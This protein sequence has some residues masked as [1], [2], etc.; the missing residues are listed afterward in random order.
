MSPL[1]SL[2][3]PSDGRSGR[4]AC[5]TSGDR[6]DRGPDSG[7]WTTGRRERARCETALSCCRRPLGRRNGTP[8]RRS[9]PSLSATRNRA[10]GSHTTVLT[11]GNVYPV[12]DL[13][14]ENYRNRIQYKYIVLWI[15]RGRTR[16]PGGR[17]NEPLPDGFDT[18]YEL[19]VEPLR[20]GVYRTVNPITGRT[21]SQPRDRGARSETA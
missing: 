13:L 18:A 6:L 1:G 8:P 7:P 4:L 19:L 15:K 20:A 9:G 11:H 3:L 12:D 5:P 10:A 21:T 14:S 17:E 16:W 2:V